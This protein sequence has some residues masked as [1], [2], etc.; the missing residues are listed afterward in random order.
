[1]PH[2]ESS[3]TCAC[4]GSCGCQ[5]DDQIEQTFLTREEYVAQLEDYLLQLKKEIVSVEDALAQLKQPA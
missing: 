4:G 1:M 3:H 5:A 2:D